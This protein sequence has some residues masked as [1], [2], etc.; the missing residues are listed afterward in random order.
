M[1]TTKASAPGKALLVGGYLV[2][3]RRNAGL[4]IATDKRFYATVRDDPTLNEEA[5]II[6]ESPQ[7]HSTWKY[8]YT[9]DTLLPCVENATINDFV[10]KTLR[11]CLMYLQPSA[12]INLKIIIQADNEFYSLLPHLE[13]QSL[14]RTPQAVQTL[15]PFLPCPKDKDGK[16]IINKTGLGSSAALVTSLVGAL[17]H[18]F[19]PKIFDIQHQEE[20]KEKI[21]GNETYNDDANENV[22]ITE[23]IHNLAQISHC[24]AQGK[25]GSGFDVSAACHGT[26]VYRR[27]PICLLPDLLQQ[28]DVLDSHSD[29]T[30]EALHNIVE[31]TPWAENMVR[32]PRDLPSPLQ[33]VLA[34]IR[35]GSESPGMAKKVQ[36][37]KQKQYMKNPTGKITHWDDLKALNAQ[38]IALFQKMQAVSGSGDHNTTEYDTLATQV[39]SEWPKDSTL[40]ELSATFAEIRTHMKEMGKAA[41]VPIEPDE[42]TDLCNATM[43]V[44]GVVTALVPGAG[45]YDAIACVYINRPHV[46]ESIGVVWANYEDKIVCPLGLKASDCGFRLDEKLE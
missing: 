22:D 43:K 31:T 28:L 39:A 40:A 34:D 15:E 14:E 19:P 7:F 20:P 3:E 4:V 42:Q 46:L 25:V 44:P 26:H 38:A 37:W 12:P 17:V 2:L 29:S 30:K 32:P 9:N 45:G 5:N 1:R 35:G 18:H 6:V 10:E 27:F 33:I 8:K 36:A 21:G 24:Y 16:A 13:A 23:S 41:N 11:V